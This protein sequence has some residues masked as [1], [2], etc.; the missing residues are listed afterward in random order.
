[1]A[2]RR[3]FSLKVIDTDEF[4]DMPD[5]SRLLYYDLGMRADDDGFVQPKKVMRLTG[6]NPD[7]LKILLTKKFIIP[8]KDKGVIVITDWKENN[9]IQKDRYTQTKFKDEFKLLKCIDNVYILD[10]QV[11]LGKDRKEL[12]NNT[13]KSVG[14]KSPDKRNPE[15]QEIIDFATEKQFSLQGSQKINRQYAYNLLRKKDDKGVPL[16]KDRVKWLIEA[17]IACR[18]KQYYPTINDFKSLFN[19]WQDLLDKMQGDKN[20]QRTR[21][22]IIG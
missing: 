15:L 5:S 14:D 21:K 16:G 17:S 11:R 9:Y 4:L 8:F 19:K 20:E 2:Q 1:M 22:P 3:M 18:G 13:D 7:D 12:G 10:T 6:A